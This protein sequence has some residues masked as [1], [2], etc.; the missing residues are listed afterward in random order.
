MRIFLIFHKTISISTVYRNVYHT[1]LYKTVYFFDRYK[2]NISYLVYCNLMIRIIFSNSAN[3]LANVNITLY[4]CKLS[5]LVVLNL[6]IR[7][8]FIFEL[9][10]NIILS[11]KKRSNI[12]S[13]LLNIIFLSGKIYNY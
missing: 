8:Y 7:L 13:V 3:F 4:I 12:C 6:G 10:F 1:L 2:Y 5:Y 11:I 9:V